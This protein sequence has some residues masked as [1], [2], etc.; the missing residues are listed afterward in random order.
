MF[1]GS[2]PTVSVYGTWSENIEIRAADDG[3]LCDLSDATE[4]TLKLID[5]VS[6]FVELTLTLG[7]GDIVL[8]STGI[9]QW[10]AEVDAMG[11]IPP[12]LYEVLL[13]IE[14]DTDTL[15]LLL[16]TVSVVE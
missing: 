12:K 7:N 9:I 14:T 15:P 5:P 1:T 2:L 4:I 8:P 16:G 13:L 10:R 6:K 3:E 11:T